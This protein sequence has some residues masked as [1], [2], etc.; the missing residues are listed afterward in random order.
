MTETYE[1]PRK[2]EIAVVRTLY[3]LLET[4]LQQSDLG[5]EKLGLDEEFEPFFETSVIWLIDE[6]IIRD[7]FIRSLDRRGRLTEPVT[8]A[9][10]CGLLR[11]SIIGSNDKKTNRELVAKISLS[12]SSY[13]SLGDFIGSLPGGFTKTLNS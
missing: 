1:N 13:S 5:V 9:Y 4:G 2:S 8:T 6:K 11:Q 3:K 12:P 10:G 7:H